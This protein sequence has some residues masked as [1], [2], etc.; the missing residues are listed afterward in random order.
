MSPAGGRS[1]AKALRPRARLMLTI[2]LELIS[3]ETVALT[4][5]VKNS[6]D[7]DATHV[8]VRL[9]GPVNDKG[10]I[11]TGQGVIEVLDDGTG[12]SGE[13][14]AGTW[15]EP[16]TAYRRRQRKST[17]GRRIL[18]E[19][20]V[21]RFASAKLASGLE[22]VSHPRNDREVRVSLD[23]SDFEN[24]DIY[25]DQVE[26]TWTE[27]DPVAFGRTGEAARL[28]RQAFRD[29]LQGATGSIQRHH[30]DAGHGTLLR[31]QGTRVDWDKALLSDLRTTL[32]RLVSPFGALE[33]LATD[34]TILLDAPASFGVVSGLVEP[35]EELERPHYT[36]NA[37]VDAL[38]VTTG[39]MTL[40][41]GDKV[42]IVDKQ[43]VNA[44]DDVPDEAM[45]L[46]CGPFTIRLRVWDRD[47]KSLTAI[48]DDQP[49]SSV[50][51]IL[52]RAAG[53]S[54][55]R[56]GFRVLPYG[57]P[58]D[59]WLRLDLRRVQSPTRRLS[60]NQ[61]V[62]YLLIGRDSNPDLVDQTNREGIVEGPAL[63]DLRDTVRQLL[64]LLETARYRIRPR[65]D[66]RHK[67]GLL[68][69]VD[70]A[71]LRAA[72]V[73]KLP[74][75]QAI[76]AMVTELQ[77]ELD[78]RTE[79]VGQVLARY[80]RL[81]TLG[82]LIDRV[83]H[84]LGQPLLVSRQAADL[85]L[86]RIAASGHRLD[87]A[88]REVVDELAARLAKVRDQT[89][90]AS[91]VLRRIEPFGGRRRGR[92]TQISIEA[93]VADAVALLDGEV[94]QIGAVVTLPTGSTTVTVDGTELQ[95]V[96]VN[97]L[98][99]SLYWLR[100]VPKERRRIEIR[101]ARNDDNSLSVLIEDSG[102]GVDEEDQEHIF[103][104]YFTTRE[105][106][107]GLGLS[108]AGEI[109][110]DFYGGELEL[111]PPDKLGGALFRATLRRRVG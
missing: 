74:K 100:Q 46:R 106:G 109:V 102:P 43:L 63:E 33:G 59:D 21:G 104:P 28:W 38:G 76:A 24:D 7:A 64:V 95:E 13:I 9:N 82:Q 17:R 55:Y 101:T 48:A 96:I 3:S 54:I 77:R 91:D 6:F 107:V 90:A 44:D 56:D 84:E 85:G 1:N 52:D 78:Q 18:G 110:S 97:L 72:I 94:Q 99:N 75:D 22:L 25:L 30:P 98:T 31:M 4:E 92:P 53:I 66:K 61:I 10:V 105:G 26:V 34:F 73:A 51:A 57:E 37:A 32:S 65:R 67:G 50:R 23:W 71:E 93:S 42:Q 41:N 39:E 68:D 89:R 29:H 12:M 87:D 2:G 27:S 108:I 35:P 20:G 36:L 60:N 80:H 86:E 83:V 15:L 62:G 5:L 19:K 79:E 49:A 58:R 16:A 14:I 11:P 81:A 88:C 111:L 8:L 47:V 70:L 45:P 40:K 103:E 69:R